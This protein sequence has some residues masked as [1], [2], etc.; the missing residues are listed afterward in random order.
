MKYIEIKSAGKSINYSKFVSTLTPEEIKFIKHISKVFEAAYVSS[1]M[2]F[3]PS[4]NPKVTIKFSE[5][6]KACKEVNLAKNKDIVKKLINKLS[7]EKYSQSNFYLNAN[8]NDQDKIKELLK[9][10]SIPNLEGL[11]TLAEFIEDSPSSK[12]K[13]TGNGNSKLKSIFNKL[14]ISYKIQERLGTNSYYWIVECT[15]EKFDD[16]CN[17]LGLKPWKGKRTTYTNGDT[18]ELII[19]NEKYNKKT[20][21]LTFI[22]SFIEEGNIDW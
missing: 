9:S 19:S 8:P 20:K 5:F 1:K 15:P 14:K 2:S 12:T 22:S 6:A 4:K 11:L 7:Y 21:T 16:I 13:V 3:N 17:T 18:S 10:K